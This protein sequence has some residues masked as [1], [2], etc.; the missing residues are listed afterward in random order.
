MEP[1]LHS[2]L[3]TNPFL[4]VELLVGLGTFRNKKTVD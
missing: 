2:E 4:T 1:G 3:N